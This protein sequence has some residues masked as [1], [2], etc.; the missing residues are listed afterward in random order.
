VSRSLDKRLAALAEAV[1]LAEGR[2]EPAA[3]VR[4]A[5]VVQRAGIRLGLG[6]ET[7]VVA[8]A[9]PTGA[10]KSTLFNALAGEEL[11]AAGV[12]RPTTS[13]V[14]A[15]TRGPVDPALLDWLGASRRHALAAD[16]REAG[17][18]LLDL[19]DYDSVATAHRLEVERII[20]LVDLLVWVADPQKYADAALHD[21]YLKPLNGHGD[22]MVVVLNQAD[23][24]D[25]AALRACRADL[26]RLLSEDGLRDLPVLAVSAREGRG[27]PELRDLLR[28][29][30]DARAAAVARLGA[31]VTGAAAGLTA[32]CEPG[33]GAR[34]LSR[35]DRRGLVDALSDAA[36]VPVVVRAV[37]GAHRREGSLSAGW[38]YGRWLARFRPDPLKRLRL[39]E[40]PDADAHTSVPRAT[41]PQRS[42]VSSAA[43]TLAAN[44]SAGLPDPWPGLARG[45][46]L[47]GEAQL[48]ERLDRVVAGADLRSRRPR[49]WTLA[50]LAQRALALVVAAGVLWLIALAALGTL[51]L[52][53]VL[54]LPK[55]HGIALPTLLLG[56]GVLLGLLLAGLARWTNRVG[57]ARRA[58]GAARILRAG[59]EEVADELVIAPVQAEL[60]A[61]DAL[62]GALSRARGR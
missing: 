28:R 53:D 1:D 26:A 47:R 51:Q 31:D 50:G 35:S 20:E 56:G 25:E 57:A 58:R 10:G 39:G 13:A 54:P 43:R 17:M 23:R 12:R 48:P 55:W 46:A 4:A 62:C 3:V 60:G 34:A 61:R 45:A 41:P 49:W 37:A 6:V 32:G 16:G 9:G 8:L 52:G 15:A 5:A 2:L 18:V 11:V 7:T 33:D 40:K 19:P 44:A 21:R 14:T 24:L 38:P 27:M 59:V 30:A 22:A 42:L 29:R 36:G